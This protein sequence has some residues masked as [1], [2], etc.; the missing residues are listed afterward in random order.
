MKY[1]TLVTGT[2]V[3]QSELLK[4]HQMNF[5]KFGHFWREIVPTMPP[6]VFTAR[7]EDAERLFRSEGRFP[8]RPGFE[9]LKKYR[10]ERVQQFVSDGI[11]ISSGESWW[12]LRSKAQQPF[13]KT[14]NVLGYMPV[15]GQIAEEFIERYSTFRISLHNQ[16]T[17][18]CK[19]LC[20]DR[21]RRIRPENNE[22]GS[23]FL[24]EFYRW[25]L[26]CESVHLI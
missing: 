8:V 18:R 11:L 10:A 4:I 3:D 16:Q 24:N 14:N 23:D 2:V 22:M 7:A 17:N 20:A 5:K 26:E 1:L 21:I 15:L 12:N 9:P 25:A 19:M 13:L 6:I